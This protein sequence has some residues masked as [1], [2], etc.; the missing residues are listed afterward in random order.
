MK[1]SLEDE[2]SSQSEY[3]PDLVH[4]KEELLKWAFHPTQMKDNLLLSSAISIEDLTKR[5]VSVDRYKYAQ[6]ENIEN[7]I[8]SQKNASSE[9][10]YARI[11]KFRC[12]LVRKITDG[13]G[14]RIFVVIDEAL[15]DNPAHASIYCINKHLKKSEI[16]EYRNELLQV[17]QENFSLE[18]IF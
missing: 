10:E 3:S 13:E 11:F 1:Y 17:I 6:R 2:Q 18:D 15:E 9:R 16:R 7:R 12:S 4:D 8:V 14:K 5:G